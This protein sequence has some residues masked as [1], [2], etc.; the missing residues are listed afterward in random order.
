MAVLNDIPQELL[1]L[2]TLAIEKGFDEV[3]L[4]FGSLG[5][6]TPYPHEWMLHL[7][8]RGPEGLYHLAGP[9]N[10][11]A[12]AE[13]EDLMVTA[14][15][16]TPAWTSDDGSYTEPANDGL[17][18]AYVGDDDESGYWDAARI[19]EWIQTPSPYATVPTDAELKRSADA[20]ELF[21]AAAQAG[22]S[23]RHSVNRAAALSFGKHLGQTPEESQAQVGTR[24]TLHASNWFYNVKGHPQH[25]R[26][27]TPVSREHLLIK[28]TSSSTIIMGFDDDHRPIPATREE[29]EAVARGRAPWFVPVAGYDVERER[30]IKPAEAKKKN[31]RATP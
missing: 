30:W 10:V 2:A 8:R 29:F 1:E 7:T 3:D 9:D 18:T 21:V 31:W 22:W 23:V 28:H 19:R 5:A 4:G 16:P 12:G 15:R 24:F 14:Q 17:P 26:H 20:V 27:G 6:D 25:R 11:A 13:C